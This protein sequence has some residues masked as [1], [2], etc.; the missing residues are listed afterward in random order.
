MEKISK[1]VI[2]LMLIF[3]IIGIIIS[4][5]G[6]PD[7]SIVSRATLFGGFYGEN[8]DGRVVKTTRPLLSIMAIRAGEDSTL[9]NRK[10]NAESFDL[11][12][13]Y[14]ADTTAIIFY[15]GD[16]VLSDTIT[17][18]HTN[19]PYFVSLECGFDM[20]QVVT[21]MDYTKHSIDSIKLTNNNTNKDGKE[22]LQIFYT[23]IAE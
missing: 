12:L 4:C 19:T 10:E 18:W 7:C 8:A 9:L 3:P 2:K 5:S 17:F 1:I 23:D 15:Y 22:N 11:P 6:E 20:K 14:T 21:K 16:F 13:Q